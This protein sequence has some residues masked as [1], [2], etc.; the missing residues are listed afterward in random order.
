V[1][2]P[3]DG[4][5][6][7]VRVGVVLMLTCLTACSIAREASRHSSPS[8][9]TTPQPV[10]L[11]VA[12][13]SAPGLD[14]TAGMPPPT[15]C[16]SIDL[17]GLG[18]GLG[19]RLVARP[20][21]WNDGGVPSLDL[22]ALVLTRPGAP[23]RIVLVGVSALPQ[24]SVARLAAP[25]GAGPIAAPR[26]GPDALRGPYGVAFTT[27]GRAVRI[28]DAHGL[29]EFEATML[30]DAVAAVVPGA[31]RTSRITD[32]ACEPSGASA[33][34]FLGGWAVLR[35][36]YR[37]HSGLTC[38]WGTVAGTVAIVE[39]VGV[40]QIPEARRDPR[41]ARAPVGQEGYYLP[42]DGLLVFRSGRRVVRVSALAD[43]PVAVTMDRLIDIV[44]PIMPLFLR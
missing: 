36:D 13:P 17:A 35:R 38:I 4:W 39:S 15:V 11:A 1:F 2:L 14:G 20:Y 18:R 41:P 21:G 27:D 37:I 42:E 26:I 8:P 34:Q 33:E 43:P 5:V 19:G 31:A 9:T 6:R 28:T 30:A 44:E 40:T 23:A 29:K 24:T 10:A 12:P 16:G 7:R 22:C 3:E 25:L 32:G